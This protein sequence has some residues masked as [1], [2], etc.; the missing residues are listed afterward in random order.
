[1]SNLIELYE[2][3]IKKLLDIKSDA[4]QMKRPHSQP[5]S[6]SIKPPQ[7]P[8]LPGIGGTSKKD[9]TKIAEQSA[10]DP[11]LKEIQQKVAKDRSKVMVKNDQEY[12]TFN[13]LGQ[14][15]LQKSEKLEEEKIEKP[16][17]EPLE[18]E[19]FDMHEWDDKVGYK[20]KL[21]SK[22]SSRED[23]MND[24]SYAR[25]DKVPHKD[26]SDFVSYH[27]SKGFAPKLTKVS[28]K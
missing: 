25:H 8:K 24:K 3:L 9:P 19:E 21:S 4:T 6:S 10:I 27:K 22:A 14:W 2:I 1:M 5:I 17:G 18:K 11:K 15:T 12:M 23:L 16:E 26:W 13:G 7:I 20:G 28:P